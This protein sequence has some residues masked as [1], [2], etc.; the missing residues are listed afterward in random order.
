[1][2]FADAVHPLYAARAVGCWAPAGETPAV[3]QTPAR[4]RL[5]IHGALDLET[6]KT[7]MI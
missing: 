4:E 1:V 5:N 2:V 3:A 6:D 7:A